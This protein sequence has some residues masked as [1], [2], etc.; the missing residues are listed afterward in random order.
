[1]PVRMAKINKSVNEMLVEM[2]RKGNR[3]TLLMG[4]QGG[5]AS[6]ENH[7]EVPQKVENRA[8]LRPSN[9]TTR[10]LPQRYK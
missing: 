1:M 7:V 2:W 4:I 6:L 9:W 8:A 10:Y 5:M 3:L